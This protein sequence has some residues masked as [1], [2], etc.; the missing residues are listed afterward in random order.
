MPSSTREDQARADIDALLSA[1]GWIVQDREELALGA[2]A[3]IAVRE[4]PLKSGFADYL[5]YVYRQP[6]G[7]IEAKKAGTPLSGVEWQA[8]KYSTGLPDELPAPRRPLPFLYE[9][10]GKETFFTNGFDPDPR[11]RRVFAFHQPQT[12]AQW[13]AE[14][15]NQL[16]R[17]VCHYPPLPT[18]GL[19]DAQ[20]RARDREPRALRRG[21]PSALADPDG[22]GLGQD[23][24]RCQLHLPHA[25]LW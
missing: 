12:L 5:L 17:R 10:T 18:H 4:F 19:W 20:I 2:G 3:G 6:V 7:A 21:Q 14:G 24:H 22:N 11:S 25:A 13:L 16:R 8:E 23:V 15:D 9:S 1:A